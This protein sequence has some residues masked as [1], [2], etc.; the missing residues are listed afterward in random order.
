[1]KIHLR[2]VV[3][4]LSATLFAGSQF[5]ALASDGLEF[6]S[7]TVPPEQ[8]TSLRLDGG[9]P[10][11]LPEG[12]DLEFEMKLRSEEHNFGYVCRV[13]L[14]DTLRVDLVSNVGWTGE[15]FSLSVDGGRLITVG[16][17]SEVGSFEFGK[18][19]NVGLRLDPAKDSISL[20]LGSFSAS[21]PV[22]LPKCNS[23][24]IVFGIQ[25]DAP[26]PSTDCPPMS[27]RNVSL[28]SLKGRE[29][30]VWPLSRHGEGFTL[31][32]L[33]SR[34]ATVLNPLWE[35]DRHLEWK[36]ISHLSITGSSP[37][38][39]VSGRPAGAFGLYVATADSL[40]FL[41]FEDGVAGSSLG[42]RSGHPYRSTSNSLVFNP[43]NGELYSYSITEPRLDRYDFSSSGWSENDPQLKFSYL[44]HN[45]LLSPDGTLAVFGGYDEYTYHASLFVRAS[46]DASWRETDLSAEISPRYLSAAALGDDG[47]IYIL[48][49]YGSRSG[50]Q[51]DS[52]QYFSDC[53]AVDPGC[54]EVTPLWT[55]DNPENEV[56][57]NSMVFSADS[58]RFY[59][60]SFRN[61]RNSTMLR[62]NSFDLKTGERTVYPGMI[63]F[64]FHDTDSWATLLK[65]NAHGRLLAVLSNTSRTGGSDIRVYSIDSQP[66]LAEDV[67]QSEKNRTPGALAGCIA[68]GVFALCA[69]LAAVFALRRH[70]GKG[71]PVAESVDASL[72]EQVSLD[73]S[74]A[75]HPVLA[76]EVSP[77][78]A[79]TALQEPQP[80]ASAALLNLIGPFRWS[81]P[82]GEDRTAKFSVSLR[83][84][85]LFILLH[86]TM[87]GSGVNSARLD[88]VF[89][90]SDPS[91]AANRRNVA[92]SR[93]RK[94][95]SSEGVG[96]LVC[97]SG[98][99][100]FRL[101]EGVGC[102][103][104][105]LWEMLP[106]KG[107]ISSLP[108]ETVL[109]ILR[110]CRRGSLLSGIDDEWCDAFKSRYLSAVDEVLGRLCRREDIREDFELCLRIADVM[111]VND[112]IDE[113]AIALKCR[114][115]YSLGRKGAALQAWEAFCSEYKNLLGE[116][117]ADDFQKIISK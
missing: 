40:Y 17:L 47:K 76:S 23:V 7:H 27:L 55:F 21:A 72:S 5:C 35:A 85:F 99:W 61:D 108:K 60:L 109:S 26:A 86:R 102:D 11:C 10:F 63:P 3:T 64:G 44:H 2:I 87:T 89:W 52:P 98:I 77:D 103:V 78:A 105:S 31:D 33:R 80:A 15:K 59:A 112:P 45:E 93:L 73:S 81:A 16:E 113:S 34:K 53:Y 24:R 57:A 97:R 114:S 22:P 42:F 1:M 29:V 18:W 79:P 101:G 92:M 74:E 9:R 28:C 41:P 95:L 88:E 116:P 39:A 94:L 51:F 75:V 14:N 43:L 70:R 37:Q 62:L 49:G 54:G 84:I 6:R 110:L 46:G 71:A 83:N 111:L 117:P 68:G 30:G 8:R 107:E 19:M 48:G 4:L 82:G 32:S 65:D 36:E 12:F 67:I 91:E 106:Q 69:L 13:I 25:E 100:E 38:I 56:F 90:N 66:Y 50:S 20:S 96:E 104:V 115:L 58:S